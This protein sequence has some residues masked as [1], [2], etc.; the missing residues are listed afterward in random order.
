[1]E[2]LLQA[3]V[4]DET[5]LGKVKCTSK[6]FDYNVFSIIAE[7]YSSFSRAIGNGN[8]TLARRINARDG[9][10]KYQLNH[11]FSHLLEMNRK[12]IFEWIHEQENVQN[13]HGHNYTYAVENH[14]YWFIHWLIDIKWD[15][16]IN[17]LLP[18]MESCDAEL[19]DLIKPLIQWENDY[20]VDVD[21]IIF[22]MDEAIKHGH[23]DIIAKLNEFK[24]S[25]IDIDEYC[26]AVRYSQIDSLKTLWSIAKNDL[27]YYD[28]L[29]EREYNNLITLANQYD[30]EEIKTFIRDEIYH[31]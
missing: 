7:Y 19:L 20:I 12:D 6:I 23:I 28:L 21:R 17:A 26:T 30:N 1:M 25:D 27:I 8:L 10:P 22:V 29:N 18:V 9:Y 14:H 3:L 2:Y 5:P 15:F 16:S 31:E 24:Y 11:N 4:S 13:Y